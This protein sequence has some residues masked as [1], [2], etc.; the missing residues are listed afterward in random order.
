MNFKVYFVTKKQ[1]IITGI[2]LLHFIVAATI[3]AVLK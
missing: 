3:F 1:L 2:I